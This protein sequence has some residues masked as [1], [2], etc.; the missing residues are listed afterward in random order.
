MASK[1]K[2]KNVRAEWMIFLPYY[3]YGPKIMSCLDTYKS[4]VMF[5]YTFTILTILKANGRR[6]INYR[7]SRQMLSIS[8]LKVLPA[9]IS[10]HHF[11]NYPFFPYATMISARASFVLSARL[12]WTIPLFLENLLRM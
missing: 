5:S 9:E 6:L 1:R 2:K 12:K 3:K 7:V 11:K 8:E 4:R 10:N